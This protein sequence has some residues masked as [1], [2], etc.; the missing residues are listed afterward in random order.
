MNNSDLNANF[1]N[2]SGRNESAFS[3]Y[4]YYYYAD[5]PYSVKMPSQHVPVLAIVFPLIGLLTILANGIVIFVFCKQKL[6]TPTS[7]LLIELAIADSLVCIPIVVLHIYIYSLGNHQTYLLYRW[8]IT[9][10]VG[11]IMQQIFRSTANWLTAMLGLQRCIAVSWPFRAQRI[12][13]IK[14]SVISFFVF[15]I[16]SSAV[17]VNEAISIEI[18]PLTINESLPRGCIRN[19]PAWYMENI[20]DLRMSVMMY[21][22]FNGFLTRFLPCIVLLL[23]TV[24]LIRSL[25]FR[26]NGMGKSIQESYSSKSKLRR[27]NI[28]VL[29]ILFVFLVAELQD[30]IAFGIYSY[31]L[32]ADRPRSVLPEGA[33]DL[34]DIYGMV[35]TLVGYQCIFWIFFV[36]S[37]QFRAALKQV[38][39]RCTCKNKLSRDDSVRVSFI[40]SSTRSGNSGAH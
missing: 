36:M 21:Y 4:Y 8:C 18:K 19:I 6:K 2:Y 34:W 23:T 9:H 28:L 37:S 40:R 17:Y 11:Y 22:I 25:C 14:M 5:E 35:V 32:A 13:T 31:E 12:C 39:C 10:H 15:V 16:G 1:T 20:I 30:A 3:D 33:D 7:V 38:F 27:T 24:S 26:S 29:V